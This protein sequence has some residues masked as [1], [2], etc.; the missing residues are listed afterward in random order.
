MPEESTTSDLVELVRRFFESLECRDFDAALSLF[1]PSPVWDMSAMGMGC[2]EGPTSI[3]GL[4]EDWTGA[5]DE[6]EI[7]L[8]HLLHLGGGVV[9]AAVIETGRPLGSTGRVQMRY[10]AVA[11][12]VEGMIVR[13]TTYPDIDEARAAAERL[14]QERADG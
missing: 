11:L 13:A 4:L 2:F 5:Y 1:G 6:W 14:A 7:E 3:R 10:A 12:L 8:E 9:F